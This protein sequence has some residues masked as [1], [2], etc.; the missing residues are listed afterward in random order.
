MRYYATRELA[1]AH[2]KNPTKAESYFWEKVRGRKLFD[3]KIN[4]QFLLQHSEIMGN[5]LYYIADFHNFEHKLI[6]EI[7]GDIHLI[8]KEYDTL[9]ENDIKALGYHVLRFTN[10]EV[11]YKWEEVE[12]KIREFLTN[13]TT[14]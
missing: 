11:L 2:R 7:D 10:D 6:I 13:H 1:R 3:L 9:R 14:H 12:R 5:K 4:R 8:Q